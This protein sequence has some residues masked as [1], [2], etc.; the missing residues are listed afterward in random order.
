MS[1]LW[2]QIEAIQQVIAPWAATYMYLNYS[3]TK[4]DPAS[5]WEAQAYQRL[6]GSNP[7]STRKT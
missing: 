5:Y 4:R 1:T 7:R 3:D 2:R 6:R